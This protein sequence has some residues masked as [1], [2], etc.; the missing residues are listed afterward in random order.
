MGPALMDDVWSYGPEPEQIYRGLVHGHPNGM[1]AFGER[2][3]EDQIWR[4]AAFVRSMSGLLD[5]NT[6]PGRADHMTGAP[7]PS[8]AQPDSPKPGEPK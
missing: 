5:S 8:S 4:L 6:A 3:T 1:L 2:L 7:P